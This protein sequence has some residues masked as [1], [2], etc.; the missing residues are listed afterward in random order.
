M[1][2]LLIE[3]D[4]RTAGFIIKGLTQERI[5]ADHAA[6][7]R[8]GLAMAQDGP[9]DVAIVDIMLPSM[10][11][12]SLVNRL[13][14]QGN[15]LP[16]LFLSAKGTVDDRVAGFQHGGDDYLVKPFAFN[17]LVVRLQALYRRGSGQKPVEINELQI[18]NLR[19]DIRRRRVYRDH[20]EIALQPLELSLLE[21]LMRNKGRVISKISIMQYVWDYHFDPQTNVVEA[22]ICQLRE[23]IDKN[24]EPKLIHTV[25][26]CGYVLDER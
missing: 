20:T 14:Q 13:R 8:D 17:E 18:A 19:M 1:K 24:Y 16:V 15:Y 12:L 9:Y 10:D 23:K 22:R 21:Y 4:T 7:G 3:D 6:D 11:G 2:V 5:S 25:R 26:G